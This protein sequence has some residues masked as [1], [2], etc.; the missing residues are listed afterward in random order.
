VD[1]TTN[2]WKTS[3]TPEAENASVRP[4]EGVGWKLQGQGWPARLN[5]TVKVQGGGGLP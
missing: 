2:K 5:E 4:V 3:P 1:T